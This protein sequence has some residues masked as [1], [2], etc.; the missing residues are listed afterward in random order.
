VIGGSLV[1]GSP[2]GSLGCEVWLWVVWC[3]KV[4]GVRKC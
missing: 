3:V 1:C 2:G 4:V